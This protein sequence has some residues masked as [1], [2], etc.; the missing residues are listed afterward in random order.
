MRGEEE[1]EMGGQGGP[2]H[3]A[4]HM[5][6]GGTARTL[7]CSDDPDRHSFWGDR[8]PKAGLAG[9]GQLSVR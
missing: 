2:R 1:T 7:E 8:Q 5:P 3:G 4:S 6:M 9:L